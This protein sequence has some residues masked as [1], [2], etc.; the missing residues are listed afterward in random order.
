MLL[1]RI[2][3]AL[4]EGTL[5]DTENDVGREDERNGK[6][7]PKDDPACDPQQIDDVQCRMRGIAKQAEYNAQFKDLLVK[8]KAD[9]EQAR[10]DYRQKRHDSQLKVQDLRH[11]VKQLTERLRCKIEQEKVVRC[12]DKAFLQVVE[13]LDACQKG[14]GCCCREDECQFD[15]DVSGVTQDKLDEELVKRISKYQQWTDAAQACFTRLVGEPAALEVR[16]AARKA[17]IDGISAALMADPA[18]TDLK[19][20]YAKALVADREV[21]RVWNGFDDIGDFVDCLCSTLNCWTNGCKA[22]SELT[23]ARAVLECKLEAGRDRCI[24]LE[25]KTVEEILVIYDKN[26]AKDHRQGEWD[27]HTKHDHDGHDHDGHDHDGYDHN[28]RDCGCGRRSGD[29][30]GAVDEVSGSNDGESSLA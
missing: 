12:I 13:E 5:M 3:S 19:T 7:A 2:T 11:Q 20:V 8:A 18:T 30:N 4:T 9:Y 14:D 25:T 24:R 27:R 22:V 16:V 21:R 23:G 29:G 6:S 10:Q 1:V 17:D 28:G 15:T 26:W